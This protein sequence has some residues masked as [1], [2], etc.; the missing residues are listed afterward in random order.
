MQRCQPHAGQATWRVLVNPTA[1]L[2]EQKSLALLIMP[3]A[4]AV[5]E[6]EGRESVEN[7]ILALSRICGSKDRNFRNTLVFLLPSTRG[8]TRLR[9][10]LAMLAA[11]AGGLRG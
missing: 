4:F 5:G 9:Q 2:T 1:D 8:L 6:G 10:T 11:S 3:P 7:R